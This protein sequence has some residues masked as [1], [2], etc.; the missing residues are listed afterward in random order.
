MPQYAATVWNEGRHWYAHTADL[1][2]TPVVAHSLEEIEDCLREALGRLYSIDA[3]NVNVTMI[4][5]NRPRRG[6]VIG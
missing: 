4:V 1:P 6:V 5:D 2:D 3:G